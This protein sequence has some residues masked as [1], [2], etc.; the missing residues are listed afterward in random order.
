MQLESLACEVLVD[1]YFALRVSSLHVSRGL[2]VRS[3]GQVVVE[4]QQHRRVAFD[5]QQQVAEVSQYVRADRLALQAPGESEQQILVDG[6]R[7][8]VRPELREPFEEGT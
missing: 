3:D 1:A 7:E 8:V 4:V 5:G 6:D 2:G